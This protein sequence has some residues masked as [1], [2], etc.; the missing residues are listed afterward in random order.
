MSEDKA[1]ILVVSKRG[2]EWKEKREGGR[3][4]RRVKDCREEIPGWCGRREK[5]HT[6]RVVAKLRRALAPVGMERVIKRRKRGKRKDKMRMQAEERRS[7]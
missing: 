5:E 2:K 3:G 4:E 1:L 6:S 7:S